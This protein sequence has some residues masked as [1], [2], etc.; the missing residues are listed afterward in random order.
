MPEPPEASRSAGAGVRQLTRSNCHAS[1]HGV[2]LTFVTGHLTTPRW[3]HRPPPR[4][5]TLD[6]FNSAH[7][8]RLS[9]SFRA[10]ASLLRRAGAGGNR[11][12]TAWVKSVPGREFK[13]RECEGVRRVFPL[14]YF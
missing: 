12:S 9:E 13:M 8:L 14:V 6:R 5:S 11:R 3:K 2:M 10:Y 7:P 1:S 4:S